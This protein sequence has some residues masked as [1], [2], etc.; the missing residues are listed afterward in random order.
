MLPLTQPRRC[1]RCCRARGSRTTPTAAASC[2]RFRCASSAHLFERTQSRRT[3]AP[4]SCCDAIAPVTSRGRCWRLRRWCSRTRRVERC[5]PRWAWARRDCSS[6][7]AAREVVRRL[8]VLHRSTDL[9]RNN[10]LFEYLNEELTEFSLV[11]KCK[12]SPWRETLR[13]KEP[14]FDT[15]QSSVES[16]S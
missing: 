7:A 10:Y 15:K 8:Q 2:F 3:S 5:S 4:G 16:R 1:R 13:R 14:W 9:P 12:H 6:C 11:L